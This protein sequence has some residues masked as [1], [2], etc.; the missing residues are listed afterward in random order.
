MKMSALPILACFMIASCSNPV[1]KMNYPITKKV[2]TVDTY[3]GTKVPDAY[4]WLEDDNSKET[5]EW[6]IAENSV[7]NDYLAK[8]PNRD[9][10]KKRLTELWNYP[11]AGVP[12]KKGDLYFHYRNN[13][14]QD[15]YVLFVQKS[16]Q[17]TARVLLDPNKLSDD[18]TVALAGI[19]VSEDSKYL[20]YRIARSGSD[21]NELYVRDIDT[22]KDLKD[23]LMWLKFTGVAWYQ[24]GFF[25]SRYDAPEEGGALSNSN[26]YHKV[27]YHKLG[28]SQEKD[29]LI[30]QNVKYPKR[31]YSVSVTDD[32]KFLILSEMAASN[33][34]GLYFKDLT[35]KDATFHLISDDMQ[36]KH[37]IVDDVN[38]KFLMFTNEGASNNR[39]V[40]V[41]AH[42]SISENWKE[43]ISEKKNVL[44]NVNLAGG[45]IVATYMKDAYSEIEI[46]NMDGKFESNLE[47]PGIGTVGSFSGKKDENIA[48][49]NFTS[50]TT[51]SIAYKYD[52]ST[53]KS[54]IFYQPKINF[55]SE[56][57]I[58]EQ[59]F[60]TSKD[61]TKVPMFI[62]YK[63]GLKLNGNNPCLLYGYG[64]FDISLTPYFTPRRMVWLENGGVFALANLRGGGE[65]GEKWHSA[66]TKM[67]KQNVFDDCIAAAEFLIKENYTNPQRLALKGGSN[68]GLLVG[69]VINQRPDLFKVAIPEVGVMDMLR[70][71]KF[72]IGWSWAGDYGTSSDSKEMFDYLY[73]YSP[74]HNITD[75]IDYPAILVTT[76][77]HDDRVVPAHSFKYIA[78]LQ[79]K[80]QGDN[81]ILI[82]I[83]SKAGHGG[84]MPTSKQIEEYTDIWSFVFYNMGLTPKYLH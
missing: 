39:L 82:R 52:F 37:S 49:Y 1:S 60:Y 34:N 23:H 2:D 57:F 41:D 50:F 84:G 11:K 55:N 25:Y 48:F 3:F 54:E 19:A 70:Y 33:G 45:K 66:G 64:G 44:S 13:G 80:Y 29:Q 32:Q 17:D 14:L 36:K 22:G 61:G 73:A 46:L 53:G 58:T 74:I 31:L 21:W 81:P 72:T 43:I 78:T 18:G 8:I 67:H 40:A 24:N 69:V 59:K 35:K 4:R 68:G 26:E 6:V 65:Y 16:L 30:Y 62:V 15:Q 71:N 9:K 76:A 75:K 5:K 38:G 28:D 51:P 27:Y 20:A 12:F 47:I 10:I 83:E 7:T 42:N 56:D 79:A 77:D 63:K